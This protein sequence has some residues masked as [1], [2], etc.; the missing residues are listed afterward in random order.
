MQN[1]QL[2]RVYMTPVRV[3]QGQGYDFNSPSETSNNTR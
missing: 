3:T 1:K 2:N